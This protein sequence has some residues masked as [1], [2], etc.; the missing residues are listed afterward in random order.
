MTA[1]T[2][3]GADEIQTNPRYLLRQPLALQWFDNDRLVKRCDCERQAGRFELFLDLLYVAIVANFAENLAED[4]SGVRLVKYILILAPSW[5]IWSD[6]RELMNSFYNDDLLQRVLILWVMALLVVYG[7]NAVLVEEDLGAMQATVGAYIVARATTNSM[8]LYYSFSSYHHRAQQRLWFVLSGLALCIYIPLFV[9]SLSFRSK[10][11]VAAVAV[12]VEELCWIFCYSPLAKRLLKARYTTAVDIPHEV[13]RVA[14]FY[15][16]VLG[17]F[18]YQIVVGSPAAVGFNMNLVHAIWTLVIAF[19]LN[20]L[21]LHNDGSLQGV[22][23][24]RHDIFAAFSWITLHLPLIASLLAGGH[25]AAASTKK[26]SLDTGERWLL[27]GSLG[28]GMFCLYGIALLHKSEDPPQLLVLDK[29]YRIIMRPIVGLIIVLIPFAHRLNLTD[30]L[31]IIM[32]LIVF[33]L[34]WENVTSLRCDAKIW[35]KWENTWP[36]EMSEV[37]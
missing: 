25:V 17:E 36:P 2:Q 11:A 14:A 33:C 37:G 27:C 34:I 21:Y 13:D 5:H 24:L 10:I 20:W 18:L 19:C 28:T 12:C 8:H 6:L 16:I 29:Q 35:E 22:H 15:I 26:S 30:F 3:I 1:A 9:D 32:S 4:V 23:P 7:N 31:S